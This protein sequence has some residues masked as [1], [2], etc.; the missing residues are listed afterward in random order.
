MSEYEDEGFVERYTTDC[1]DAS[2]ILED[3]YSELCRRR[4]RTDGMSKDE[5]DEW[6]EDC[7]LLLIVIEDIETLAFVSKDAELLSKFNAVTE[8]LYEYKA[9]IILSNIENAQ[10]SVSGPSNIRKNVRDKRYAFMLD[11]IANMKLFETSI[12][13]QRRY[14]KQILL[15]EG[16][17]YR[18]GEYDKIKMILCDIISKNE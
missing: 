5:R 6:L 9:C 1:M 13:L 10:P 15:G 17:L 11:D 12:Q 2:W 14:P 18:N 3:V 7:P 8:E 16:Y 4:D